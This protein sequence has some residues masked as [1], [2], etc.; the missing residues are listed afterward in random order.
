MPPESPA[1]SPRWQVTVS[2]ARCENR[3]DCVRVCPERVFEMRRPR[4][5]NPLLWLKMKAHGGLQAFPARADACTGCM[6]CV[7]ACP[8][9]AIVVVARNEP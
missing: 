9:Q 1:L 2:E 4:I 6:A 8:E 3:R 5:R 7:S